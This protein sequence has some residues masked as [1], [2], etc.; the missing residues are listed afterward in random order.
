M[1]LSYIG[2]GLWKLDIEII[3]WNHK[4]TT[5]RNRR[6]DKQYRKSRNLK[7]GNMDENKERNHE[8]RKRRIN[9]P[10][11][12]ANKKEKQPTKKN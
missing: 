5:T 4:K 8:N 10:M 9:Q 6:K 11:K 3:K 1:N 12:N 2:K 7:S